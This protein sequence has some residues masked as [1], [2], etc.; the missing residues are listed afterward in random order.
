[1][2]SPERV[3]VLGTGLIGTSIAMAALGAGADVRGFDADPAVL[4]T[5]SRTG[6]FSSAATLE[7]CVNEASL[8]FVCTPI[9]TIPELVSRALSAARSAIVSDVGSVKSHVVAEVQRLA[10]PGSVDRFVG[11]HPM[12]GSERSGPDGASPSLLDGIA[13][14]LTPTEATEDG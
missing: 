3:A 1:M 12:G 13:W 5:A 9:P 11:G 14:V 4:E 10:P 7:D 6:A 8:V 2:T